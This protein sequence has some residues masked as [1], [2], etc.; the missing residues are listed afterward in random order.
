MLLISLAGPLS[1]ALAVPRGVVSL[2][3]ASTAVW[4]LL[5]CFAAT[6]A[7]LR[8]WLVRVILANV[9]A[10]GLVA[11]LALS[12]PLD[13]MSVLLLAVSVEVAA[14]AA[15]QVIALTSAGARP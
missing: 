11:A 6:R 7:E 2:A 10:A 4:A 9:A 3:A 8:P 1:Q 12:R 5:L 14:F 13:A 15:V